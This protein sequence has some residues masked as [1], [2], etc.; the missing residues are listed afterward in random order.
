MIKITTLL[1]FCFLTFTTSNAQV[2]LN[3]FDDASIYFDG[4]FGCESSLN[5]Y[6]DVII[7]MG[8]ASAGRMKFRIT[9]VNISM[10]ERPGE[11]GCA[12]ICPPRIIISFKCI[13]S[14]CISD[15]AF[16]EMRASTTSA[17]AI[18]NIKRGKKAFEY[19]K[20]LKVF[21]AKN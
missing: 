15:P 17:F 9:D 16:T 7:N 10:E 8:S 21:M 3:D 2:V 12:D 18:Y 13:K 20:A 4:L 19:L 11:P 5:E 6:G 1:L 14:G